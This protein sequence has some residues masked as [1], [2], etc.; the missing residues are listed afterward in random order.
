M[1]TTLQLENYHLQDLKRFCKCHNIFKTFI[2][3][4]PKAGCHSHISRS[5]SNI[6]SH[7]LLENLSLNF[8][9]SS[10]AIR[11]NL[12]HP[13]FFMVYYYLWCFSF[14]VNYYFQVSFIL[15]VILYVAKITQNNATEFLRV[16]PFVR[17]FPY[18]MSF[19]STYF[20]VSICCLN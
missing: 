12:L 11:V 8:S 5:I 6:H 2:H 3:P 15:K 19:L 9:S 18:K 16:T 4:E 17:A 14:L 1:A 10:F 13:Y 20:Y 7:G